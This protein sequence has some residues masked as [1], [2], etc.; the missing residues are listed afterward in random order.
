MTGSGY[1]VTLRFLWFVAG[2][3][4][5]IWLG[6]EDRN[7]VMVSVLAAILAVSGGFTLLGRTVKWNHNQGR[8]ALAGLVVVGLGAGAAVG[9]LAAF[10][11]V[12]KVGL[13]GHA[14]PDFSTSQIQA[15]LGRTPVWAVVGA[16]FGLAIGILFRSEGKRPPLD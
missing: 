10:L 5:F 1:R 3:L 7:L 14:S 6:Y 2:A 16:L 11:M 9:P 8:S 12:F 15:V 13:H 4:W